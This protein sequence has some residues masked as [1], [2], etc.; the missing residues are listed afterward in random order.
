MF[1]GIGQCLLDNPEYIQFS[2]P[3]LYGKGWVHIYIDIDCNQT[4]I[5]SYQGLQ[6]LQETV[7]FQ[8][9]GH[10]P[11]AD[12]LDLPNGFVEM[13]TDF[14][15]ALFLGFLVAFELLLCR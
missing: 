12:G 7:G 14:P 4:E 3:I 6:T 5:I 15:E 13:L 8:L 9:H 11:T 1:Y 10:Q 2:G